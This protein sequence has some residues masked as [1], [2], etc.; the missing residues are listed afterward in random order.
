[1]EGLRSARRISGVRQT[2]AKLAAIAAVLVAMGAFGAVPAVAK[3]FSHG[4]GN[5]H[6]NGPSWKTPKWNRPGDHCSEHCRPT[7]LATQTVFFRRNALFTCFGATGGINTA[8]T[9]RI[10][11]SLFTVTAVVTVHAPPGTTVSGQLTQS[12]CARLKFFS[13]SIG[14]TGVRSF[15]VSDVRIRNDAFVWFNDTAGDFQITP[16]V[17]FF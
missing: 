7:A 1:M 3:Q 17:F 11:A 5:G 15:T 8:N 9:A 6:G 12:G 10:T 13:F 14:A 4:N 16:E 2:G